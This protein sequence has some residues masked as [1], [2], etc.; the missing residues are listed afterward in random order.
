MSQ[1]TMEMCPATPNIYEHGCL[2]FK[3]SC[4]FRQL[5]SEFIHHLIIR[6]NIYKQQEKN[7]DV[8]IK[9]KK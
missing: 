6:A 4:D 9:I 5:R 2:Q 3:L 1:T 7:Q 8:E